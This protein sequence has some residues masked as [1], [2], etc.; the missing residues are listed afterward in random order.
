PVRYPFWGVNSTVSG[1]GYNLAK[2]LTTLGDRVNF[3]SIIGKDMYGKLVLDTLQAEHIPRNFV[4]THMEQTAQSVILY[5]DNGQRQINVDLKN[6]QEQNYP[7]DSFNQALKG[8]A[9]AALCNI[10]FS[11]HFLKYAKQQGIPIATD[12]HAIADL[13][14]GYNQDFM[15]TADI[16]FMSNELLPMP[17]EEWARQVMNRFGPEII[18]IGL[19]SQGALLAVRSDNAMERIP[20]VYTREVINTIGAG[21]ALFSA[22]IHTYAQSHDPYTAIQYATTFASYKIGTTGAADG[23]LTEENLEKWHRKVRFGIARKELHNDR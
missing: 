9:L 5:D 8:C 23:F 3:I 10:N 1:V 11:R 16:L 6:I 13:E 22:F 15:N 2:A 21:D 17:P 20:A 12:V 19:G 4:L 18:V 7:E 14:D